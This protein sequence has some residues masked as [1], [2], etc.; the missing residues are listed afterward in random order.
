MIIGYFLFVAPIKQAMQLQDSV[1]YNQQRFGVFAAEFTEDGLQKFN[2]FCVTVV[3]IC[4]AIIGYFVYKCFEAKSKLSEQQVRAVGEYIEQT[5]EAKVSVRE[6][7]LLGA[8][9]CQMYCREIE[10]EEPCDM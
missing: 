6:N 8:R 10:E 9:I 5:V 2:Y 4:L 1:H 3:T 7:L